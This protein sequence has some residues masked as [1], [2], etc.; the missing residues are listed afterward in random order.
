MEEASRQLLDRSSYNPTFV[1]IN[2][3]WYYMSISK[4]LTAD[5]IHRCKYLGW[6]SQPDMGDTFRKTEAALTIL[7]RQVRRK[8]YFQPLAFDQNS[9][10]CLSEHCLPSVGLIHHISLPVMAI[11]PPFGHFS[12]SLSHYE[13]SVFMCSWRPWQVMKE[14]RDAFGLCLAPLRAT[15]LF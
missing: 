8:K 2:T 15:G 6:S 14:Y 1:C 4:P 11:T 5:Q 9:S 7:L 10:P 3:K 13:P 12:P